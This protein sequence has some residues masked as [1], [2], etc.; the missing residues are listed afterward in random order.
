[1]NRKTA[2]RWWTL[3]GLLVA[4]IAWADYVGVMADEDTGTVALS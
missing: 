4:V 3:A 2:I 1:M